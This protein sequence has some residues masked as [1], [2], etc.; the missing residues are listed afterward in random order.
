MD[1]KHLSHVQHGFCGR[2][3]SK[4]HES[5]Q[6]CATE[7][8]IEPLFRQPVRGT[9]I[10]QEV[11]F[12]VPSDLGPSSDVRLAEVFAPCSFVTDVAVTHQKDHSSY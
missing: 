2:P 5:S 8:M 3:P 12:G 9:H 4:P 1:G 11:R 7:A 6:F 10:S